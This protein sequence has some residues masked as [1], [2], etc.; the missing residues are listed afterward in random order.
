MKCYKL[1]GHANPAL[2]LETVAARAPG[3]GQVA[4]AIKA[5]SL[6][7]R[8]LIVTEY[9][10]D[11]V[12]VSDGAGVIVEVGEGVTDYQV[13]DRVAI[14]FMP[15][16]ID[17]SY[18]EA[19]KAS[20][21]GGPGVDGVL[22]EHFIVST[23][24]I[25]RIPD[26]LSFEEAATLP[27]AAVTAW[28]AL[29]EHGALAPGSTVLLQG[30]GGVSI[31]A[32]QMAKL[33]GCRVII[34]SSSDEKLARAR[35]LGADETIN[36]RKTPEWADEVLKLTNGQGVDL[37]VDVTGPATLNLTTRATRFGGRISLIGVLSGFNGTIDIGILEK[38]ITLQG[39]YVG[40]VSTLEKVARSGIKPY[41][42]QVFTF[43]EA[44]LAY[45]T[46]KGGQHFGKVV[47]QF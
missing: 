16:W 41:I 43:E 9:A 4:I 32:L 45:H 39:I 31:F 20:S 22:T 21:L 30:T 37:A 7:Y 18:S 14:G 19:K 12:P 28:S 47:I 13:G 17:G 35:E 36:Y 11:S 24:G 38:R 6:N 1:T 15:D 23:S 3:A 2:K 26:S 42:D 5:V 29:F 46:L 33:A 27:C 44:E 8:D 10:K 34:T 25:C 40:P